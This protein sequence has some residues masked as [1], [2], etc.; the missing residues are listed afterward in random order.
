MPNIV[1]IEERPRKLQQTRLYQHVNNWYDAP[2]EEIL[3]DKSK[4]ATCGLS[5]RK[6]NDA[7]AK[8]LDRQSEDH[9][10]LMKTLKQTTG[11]LSIFSYLIPAENRRQNNQA[12]QTRIQEAKRASFSTS[13]NTVGGDQSSEVSADG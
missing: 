8:W 5:M 11:Q 3:I 12:F 4:L 6:T 9:A 1:W 13:S 2:R 10:K 7:I